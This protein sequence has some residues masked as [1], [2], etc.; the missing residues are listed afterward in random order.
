MEAYLAGRCS[1]SVVHSIH[2]RYIEQNLLAH[3][4]AHRRGSIFQP[5]T[6]TSPYLPA[7]HWPDVLAK[8]D[9]NHRPAESPP[10]LSAVRAHK[11][12]SP[13]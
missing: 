12:P 5:Y 10:V 6:I 7:I 1:H 4:A 3:R 9:V 8:H 2:K 13:L 11:D